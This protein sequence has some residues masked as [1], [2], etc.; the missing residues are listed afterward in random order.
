MSV[1]KFKFVSPGIF[2]NEIDNSQLPSRPQ[3]VGPVIIG[4]AE[5]GPAFRPTVINSFSD[6]VNTFG[7]PVPGPTGGDVWRHGVPQAPTYA[8][9]AAQAYLKNNSPITFVRVLGDQND[10]QDATTYAKA[11]YKLGGTPDGDEGDGGAYALWLIPSASANTAVT[12]TLAAIW[13]CKN[14]GVQL[15]SSALRGNVAAAA[16]ISGSNAVMKSV[17][18][19]RQYIGL[20]KDDSHTNVEQTLFNFDRNSSK[21]IRKVFNTN[22]TLTNTSIVAGGSSGSKGKTYWLGPTYERA[23]ADTIDDSSAA[24]EDFGVILALGNANAGGNDFNF[25]TRA[26]QTGWFISQDV[27]TTN[28]DAA[29]TAVGDTNNVLSPAYDPTS[30][31]SVTKLFKIH[32]LST[33]EWE[34]QNLKIS[35]TDIKRSTNPDQPYGSFSVV[36]RKM[37]DTDNSIQVVEKFSN[38]NLNPNSLNYLARKIGD[39]YVSWDTTSRRNIEYGNYPNRSRFLRVEMTNMV[40]TGQ[41]DPEFLP[42]GVHG[43]VKFAS[44]VLWADEGGSQG[45]ITTA[46]SG[47]AS[48]N[49]M[50]LC[51]ENNLYQAVETPTGGDNTI[52]CGIATDV[53]GALTALMEFPSLPLRV[54]AS[55]GNLSDPTEAYFGVDVTKTGSA[56]LQFEESVYDLVR[57]LPGGVSSF[58]T[59]SSAPYT[60]WQYVFSLD[61]ISG[62]AGGEYSYN[63]GS[64]A[65]GK[66][67]TAKSG[68][69]RAILD[70]GYD[71]FTTVLAGG[72]DGLDITEKEPFN[73]TRA[74]DPDRTEKSSYAFHSLKKAI[75]MIADPE[76]VPMNLA[77]M[78]GI[79][80]EGLTAHLVN[81]CENRGDALAIIDL[82]GGY[83]PNTEDDST[84]Q[85][86][87]GTR[88]GVNEVV[89]NLE[90]RGLNSSYGCAYWPWVRIRDSINGASLWAPP[91]V[92][93]LGTLASSE[94]KTAPWFAPAGFNRGGLS[95]GAAGIPVVGVRAKLTVA[96]RDK[97][98]DAGINPIA[99]FPAEGIVVFGQKTLQL[100]ESALDRINV[101]RLMIHIK[102]EI[103][104]IATT[105]LFEQNVSATWNSFRGKAVD[106]LT[107]VQTG[108]GLTDF[109]VVLDETTTTPDLVDRNI[110]YAKVFLKPARAI[111]FIAV[112]FNITRTGAAFAD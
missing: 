109:R 41:A 97:L 94:R 87:I 66:S 21:Y 101:R 15:S 99:S 111:E 38:C 46:E 83:K 75:D 9:Y 43:P 47:S 85:S 92:A 18:A 112:D 31:A 11:G 100:T 10:N 33:G 23:V 22:P 72:F 28:A 48:T 25:K 106:F 95:T 6:F 78:P 44:W 77:V 26:A 93:A 39:T 58:A 82:K 16:A 29:G 57:P 1:K 73:M 36:V 69:Y 7:N 30:D 76:Y 42:F 59:Q 12:G 54:S 90:N 104:K 105:V 102:R 50:V 8:A 56:N 89:D 3:P 27:R 65:A 81:T 63:S 4:R 79:T 45:V 37:Q 40:D 80:N 49:Y 2:V 88:G 84:E 68:S 86:R 51:G 34:Q 62:T 14:G 32:S 71:R 60:D 24:G 70:A 5:R 107:S 17:G 91:S 13:Y 74:L 108:G 103:S 67:I 110:L 19:A 96:D 20:I 35:I 52:T 55:D 53:G 61:D 98:Y 64:R